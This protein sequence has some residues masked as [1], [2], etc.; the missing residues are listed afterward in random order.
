MHERQTW[1]KRNVKTPLQPIDDWR[2]VFKLDPDKEIGDEALD[3]VCLSGTDAIMVGGSSGVTFENTVDLMSRIRRYELP[4]VLEV[5][6]LDAVVPGFDAYMI[7]MVLNTNNANWLVGQH[8]EAIQQY[9]YMIPWD[10]LIPE[11]YII[12]NPDATAAKITGAD[13]QLSPSAAAAYAQAG[14]RLMR[15]PVI[16]AE[17]SGMFGDMELVKKVK[18]SLSHAQLFYG[19]GIRTIEQAQAAAAAA[20]TVVV[21]NVVYDDLEAALATVQAVKETNLK[22]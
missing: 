19:G 3:R 8:R 7:P 22:L 10:L 16:Y 6:E 4:A 13:T 11:G 20:N 12:L 15:L 1:R 18:S 21:G 9:G 17:Y 2:H 5:S 14:D